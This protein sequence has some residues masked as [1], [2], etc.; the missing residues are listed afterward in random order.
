MIKTV[1]PKTI[2]KPVARCSSCDAEVTKYFTFVS[3]T[4][5]MRVVCWECQMREEK[6]FNADRNFARASRTGRIPR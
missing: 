6:G 2:E 1:D 5:E 4:D 3:P